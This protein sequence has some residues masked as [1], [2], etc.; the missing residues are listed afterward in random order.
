M[1]RRIVHVR[2]TADLSALEET[3]T[4]R[5][6]GRTHQHALDDVEAVEMEGG[7]GSSGGGHGGVGKRWRGGGVGGLST[8]GAPPVF[9]IRL[10]GKGQVIYASSRDGSD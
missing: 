6:T 2:V 4:T 8:G 5:G 3:E 9:V 1:A 7:S 10:R